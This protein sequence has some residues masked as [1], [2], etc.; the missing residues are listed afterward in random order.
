MQDARGESAGSSGRRAI[1]LPARHSPSPSSR[2]IAPHPAILPSDA[3]RRGTR[4]TPPD[5][6]GTETH[7][8]VLADMIGSLVVEIGLV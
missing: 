6:A 7:T 4:P 5:K 8:V 3:P 2:R 1:V